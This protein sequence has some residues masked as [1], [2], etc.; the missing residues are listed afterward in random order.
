MKSRNVFLF[1]L[2]AFILTI[3][4]CREITVTTKVH[5]DGSFTRTITVTGD[6]TEVFTKNL[7]Y[8]VDNSWKTV[9]SRDTADA[10]QF[11]ITYSKTFRSD[12]LLN[13]E[14]HSDTSWMKQLKRKVQIRKRFAFFYSYLTFTE[15]IQAANPF[16][17]I[18][19]QDSLSP[20]EIKWLKN[21]VQPV[22]SAD[23]TRMKNI[24]DKA[25]RVVVRSMTTEVTELLEKGIQQLHDPTL[26]PRIAKEYQD[27]LFNQVGD[28]NFHSS[29]D[30]ITALAQWSGQK[31]VLEITTNSPDL[32][33]SFD[34]KLDFFT[35]L[36]SMH[37]Y[38]QTVEMPGLITE[39]NALTLKGNQVQWKVDPMSFLLTDYRMTVESRVVNYWMFVLT[40]VVILALIILLMVRAFR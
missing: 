25:L 12:D 15:T 19:L 6:S 26:A 34:K 40:G 14:I 35:Q 18:P 22:T 33:Q 21:E 8:P 28:W 23:S 4:S 10:K 24:E 11:V 9:A 20:T 32:F 3:T 38:T 17:R 31:K 30:F 2:A 39:T 5:K 7:P 1:L 16:T 37:D 36:V 27:S 29:K 13:R